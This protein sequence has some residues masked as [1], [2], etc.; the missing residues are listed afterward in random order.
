MTGA[1]KKGRAG[2]GSVPAASGPPT[3]SGEPAPV[4]HPL[5]RAAGEDGRLPPW[6]RAT[7]ERRE[8]LARVADLMGEWAARLG[9]PDGE[10]TRWRAAGLLHDALKDADAAEL[11]DRL[12]EEWPDP[13]LHAPA[14]AAALR[15]EGVQDEE[16]LLALSHHPVG[17]PGFGTLGLCLYAADWLDPGRGFR[18]AARARLR[19]RM[20][21]ERAEV[22]VEVAAFRLRRLLD[23]RL[24]VL[25]VSVR[26]WN[27]LLE[28][29]GEGA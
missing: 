8:H 27:R 24:P 21:E 23:R 6:A 5:I 9:L 13:V 28:G 2:R 11:A 18:E 16:L 29:R 25:P 17:H 19:E 1:G 20:P 15:S 4:L 26:F 7:P 10:R 14:V 22:A 3:P 12:E